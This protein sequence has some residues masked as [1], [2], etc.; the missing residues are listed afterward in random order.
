MTT[1]WLSLAAAGLFLLPGNSAL[2]QSNSAPSVQ[3]SASIQAYDINR[4]RTLVGIVLTYTA[5]SQTAPHGPR[6]TLQTS[7]GVVD[8]HLGDVRTLSVNRFTIQPGD[9]LRIIGENVS[10]AN[11]TT[12]FL[13][14]ILQKGTQAIAVR[15]TRGFLIPPSHPIDAS[16]AKKQAGVM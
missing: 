13:A 2:A 7:S 16:N 4:E 15:T 8:V 6:L 1:K 11:N 5:S 14:R 12:Q 3:S 9:T 10:F